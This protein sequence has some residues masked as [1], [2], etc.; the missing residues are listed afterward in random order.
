MIPGLS[1]GIIKNLTPLQNILSLWRYSPETLKCLLKLETGKCL[2]CDFV[3]QTQ[4]CNYTAIKM[5]I[6]VLEGGEVT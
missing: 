1:S 3:S 4:P 6:V 2:I 5:K